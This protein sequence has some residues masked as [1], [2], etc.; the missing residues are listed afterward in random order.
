MSSQPPTSSSFRQLPPMPSPPCPTH[1]LAAPPH[2]L[3]PL[4]P[5]THWQLP[6]MSLPH[7]RLGCRPKPV[8]SG[9][10]E[11]HVM[12]GALCG[13]QDQATPGGGGAQGGGHV[14]GGGRGRHEGGRGGQAQ[15]GKGTGSVGEWGKTIKSP[16]PQ[17]RETGGA[18]WG[19]LA[20]T[21]APLV[22]TPPR[23]IAWH[24]HAPALVP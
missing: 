16:P 4:A 24:T 10:L 3:P 15:C 19:N 17:N 13:A 22:P 8:G 18:H 9:T 6:P 2:A 1:P 7:R 20:A 11:L 5:L 21:P 23:V 12:T 14:R